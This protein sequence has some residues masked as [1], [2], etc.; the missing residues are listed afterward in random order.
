MILFLRNIVRQEIIGGQRRCD[1]FRQLGDDVSKTDQVL[2][3][4]GPR[5]LMER[6]FKAMIQN[7]TFFIN[8]GLSGY[9]SFFLQLDTLYKQLSIQVLMV[10]TQ[11]DSF[12]EKLYRKWLNSRT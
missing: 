10:G 1:I 5:I 3:I 7:V 4:D 12:N 11:P 6:Y 8:P 2:F 9:Q